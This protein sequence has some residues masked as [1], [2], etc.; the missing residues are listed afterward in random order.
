MF[1]L[2][3]QKPCLSRYIESTAAAGVVQTHTHARTL[4][5][6]SISCHF[7]TAL[8]SSQP[9][10]R[11]GRQSVGQARRG[12]SWPPLSTRWATWLG[13]S[14]L[15]QTRLCQM[16]HV[17]GRMDVLY[18]EREV[19]REGIGHA[20]CCSNRSAIM[21]LWLSV[22]KSLAIISPSLQRGWWGGDEGRK[23]FNGTNKAQGDR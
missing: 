9:A 6:L 11:A 22:L 21:N 12:N 19:W 2:L 18:P 13:I 14:C 8:R 20:N 10:S 15:R 7:A 1:P 4:L 5:S 17:A 16:L 23:R 3:S